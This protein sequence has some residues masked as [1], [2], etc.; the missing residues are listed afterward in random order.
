MALTLPEMR[1]LKCK[2]VEA[3]TPELLRQN[4]GDGN[5]FYLVTPIELGLMAQ[6]VPSTAYRFSR[7]LGLPFP[8]ETAERKAMLAFQLQSEIVAKGST[9]DSGIINGRRD[10]GSVSSKIYQLKRLSNI[11]RMLGV[12]PPE[13]IPADVLEHGNLDEI[14]IA[15]KL[16]FAEFMKILPD[17]MLP[18][19]VS[20]K[21]ADLDS[22]QRKRFAY[23][24][25]ILGIA[26]DNAVGVALYGSASRETDQAKFSDYDNYL[27]VKD[28]SLPQ[29]YPYLVG[30]R[31]VNP[32]DGKPVSFNLIEESTFTKF[33]RMHHDPSENLE[34]GLVLYGELK[35]P[36]AS[37]TETIERGVS[38]AVLRAKA[39]KSAAIWVAQ[40]PDVLSG[41]EPLFSFF[42][43]SPVFIV[44]AG[45]NHAL[46][47]ASRSRD[48]IVA[49]MRNISGGSALPY[50]PDAAYL[51][52]ATHLAV[53]SATLLLEHFF[54]GKQFQNSF[55]QGVGM[56]SYSEQRPEVVQA[57]S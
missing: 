33:A 30:K 15:A 51:R 43:K 39:L 21:R 45:L 38:H 8:E 3:I 5:A 32:F 42:Q 53:T 20:V 6:Y 18:V 52:D 34:S 35:F 41:K 22:D 29:L 50:Q 14:L 54:S 4:S 9:I 11:F 19:P 36:V 7:E 23:L 25:D 1:P 49:A 10:A 57:G 13:K 56:H 48:D 40:E 28:G 47:I 26:G 55:M 17:W 27:V 46:G 2:L 24:E 12:K 16:R 44:Q 37:G 31:F